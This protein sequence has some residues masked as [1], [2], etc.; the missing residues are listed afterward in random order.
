VTQHQQQQ[1]N[2]FNSME[3]QLSAVAASSDIRAALAGLACLAGRSPILSVAQ[4]PPASPNNFG[5]AATDYSGIWNQNRGTGATIAA[6]STSPNITPNHGYSSM[7]R[8]VD[9]NVHQYHEETSPQRY[10][11]PSVTNRYAE[12]D[13]SRQL[14]RMQEMTN[15][16]SAEVQIQQIQKAVQAEMQRQ[17]EMRIQEERR[18]QEEMARQNEIRRREEEM[19]RQEEMRRREEIEH[20]H[21]VASMYAGMDPH[22]LHELLQTRGPHFGHAQPQQNPQ[23]QQH[24]QNQPQQPPP[25]P[26]PYP[27]DGGYHYNSG[28]HT[29]QDYSGYYHHH[30][31]R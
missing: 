12:M 3:A 20:Q 5:A 8:R 17:E 13:P 14:H 10:N 18:R 2:D 7:D 30:H 11:V 26:P 28:H 19:R 6:Q 29:Y 15:A 21:R 9:Q 27:N 31:Q 24:L 4:P 25:P 22:A 1:A 16:I 23:N